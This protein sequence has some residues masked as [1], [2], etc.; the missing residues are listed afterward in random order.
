[1]RILWVSNAPWA[2]SGYGEQ[3]NLFTQRFAA[4]GHDVAIVANHGL[5]ER[6]TTWHGIPVFPQSGED[7]IQT[8]A[9]HWKSDVN[10]L[11]YDTWVMHPDQWPDIHMAMWAPI[12]HWPIPA[13]VL[14]VIQHDRV[15]PI[16][17]SRFG[18]EWMQKF[19]LEPL[20]VPHGVDTETFQPMPEARQVWRERMEIPEDAFLVGMVAANSG[21]NPHVSRKAFPQSFD[22]FGRF[23]KKHKDAYLYVHSR[24]HG[25]GLGNDLLRLAKVMEIPEDRFRS[26]E[27]HAWH[28]GVMDHQ[29]LSGVYNSL[30]V[31]LNPSMG[32]GFG[33]PIVEAQACG[34]PVITANHSAMPELTHAGWMVQGDRWWDEIQCGFAIMPSINSIVD[35]L[36]QAYKN[37][38]NSK[39]REG[40]RE[41][42]LSYDADR[43]MEKYW[44]PA[45]EQ[46]AK[47]HEI[48]PL[49]G[50]V[51]RQVRRAE[52]RKAAKV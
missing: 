45:L 3:T 5:Q 25:G 39:L 22:A 34:V 28:L 44:T 52:E 15:R 7:S 47:P 12:D 29:F 50:K 2:G 26:P 9:K 46:L 10:I 24:M 8:F 11:L 49:N 51:S 19:D 43:V 48:P 41:F 37:R 40:A 13:E 23:L 38:D 27:V 6:S 1:M 14:G 20:Y 31:L 36:E 32:E 16:A 35:C 21:W 30:D 33:V 4:A 18:E 42:A 17:M